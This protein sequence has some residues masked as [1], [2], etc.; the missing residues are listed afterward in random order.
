M[1][2]H[3]CSDES[4]EVCDDGAGNDAA[5]ISTDFIYTS[6]MLMD[7]MRER[8]RASEGLTGS[9]ILKK[10]KLFEGPRSCGEITM[11]K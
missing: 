7:I 1:P 10:K 8:V 5:A 2:T 6:E 4:T 11:K 3:L 9:E